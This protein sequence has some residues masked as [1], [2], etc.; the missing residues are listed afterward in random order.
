MTEDLQMTELK[1]KI[2]IVD[3]DP[4]ALEQVSLIL[5]TAGY[6]VTTAFSR[7]EGEEMLLQIEPD[8]AILDLMMEEKDSGFVLCHTIKKMYPDTKVILL[9]A[10]AAETGISFRAHSESGRSWIQAD[11][12]MDK[13][14]R[15]EQLLGAVGKLLGP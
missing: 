7:M 1:P 12:M 4:D 8:L 13:P 10:V 15:S 2:L 6:D 14:A 11:I 3:D 5:T 9:S